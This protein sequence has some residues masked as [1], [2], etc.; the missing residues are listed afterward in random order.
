MAHARK[1]AGKATG[2]VP[3]PEPRAARASY[4]NRFDVPATQTDHRFDF[5]R[6]HVD[7]AHDLWNG[8]TFAGVIIY[9]IGGALTGV[10]W[11][12]GM[13]WWLNKVTPNRQ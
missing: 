7:G 9:T 2:T 13:R 6:R 8:P 4:R 12:F 5:L 10:L 3:G 1:V 11:F